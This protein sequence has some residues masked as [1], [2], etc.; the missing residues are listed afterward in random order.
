MKEVNSERGVWMKT[1]V[2]KMIAGEFYDPSDQELVY[3]RRRARKLT[4][5][6]NETL[7]PKTR[8]ELLKR[9]FGSTGK[10]LNVEPC[11]RVDYGSNISVGEHF[12][13]NFDCVILD[14]CEVKIGD[15]CMFAPGVHIYTAAH[16]VDPVERNSGLEFG[17][18]VSI[19]DNVWIGGRAIINP[20]VTLGDNVVVASGAVVTKSFGDNVVI[21]GNPAKIIK[22]IPGG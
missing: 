10:E 12:F 19:G 17:K 14:I 16:P 11:I 22:E 18:P 21:G 15:N 9:L 2:E 20:G 4:R 1:E 13:A 5:E 3:A 6:I 8:A 7:E